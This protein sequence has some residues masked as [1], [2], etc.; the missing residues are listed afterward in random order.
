M[1]GIEPEYS[2][3]FKCTAASDLFGPAIFALLTFGIAYFGLIP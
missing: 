1:N 3:H 2:T